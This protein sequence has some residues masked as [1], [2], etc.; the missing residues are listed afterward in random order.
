MKSHLVFI[1]FNSMINIT[2]GSLLQREQFFGGLSVNDV[3][4][5]KIYIDLI[6]RCTGFLQTER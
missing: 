5:L 3:Q 4:G 1:N 2:C 6:I